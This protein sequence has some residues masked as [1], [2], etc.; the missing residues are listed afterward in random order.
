MT[1]NKDTNVKADVQSLSDTNE[2]RPRYHIFELTAGAIAVIALL[3]MMVLVFADVIGRYLFA[4]PIAGAYQLG[5]SFMVIL[6]FA[7]LPVVTS[8]ESHLTV[9]F[10]DNM[11]NQRGKYIQRSAINILSGLLMAT[12][13]WRLWE[14][15]EYFTIYPEVLEIIDIPLA[16]FCY[17]M[18]VMSGL[19]T[20]IHFGIAF[21]YV[22]CLSADKNG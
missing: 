22:K 17:F 11:F 5:S 1:M 21:R 12:V 20:V 10:T 13:C 16:V 14:Q 18:S 15:G 6:L 19:T 3:A 8:Q 7:G 4:A 2:A 9:G